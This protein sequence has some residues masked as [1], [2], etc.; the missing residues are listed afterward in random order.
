MPPPRENFTHDIV[1]GDEIA[2]PEAS[3]SQSQTQRFL[4]PVPLLMR[5]S[6]A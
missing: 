4:H 1:F 5:L 2:N 6:Q 3:Q